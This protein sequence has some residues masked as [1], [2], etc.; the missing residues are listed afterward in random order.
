MAIAFFSE[1]LKKAGFRHGFSTRLASP[2]EVGALVGVPFEA[3][4]RAKQ[5]HSARVIEAEHAGLVADE[6]DALVSRSAFAVAIQT[7]DCVPI[8]IADLR[9]G[10]VAAVHAGWRGVVSGIAPNAIDFLGGDASNL[11]AAIGPCICGTCFEVGADVAEKIA[12]ATDSAVIVRRAGEKA[13]VDLRIAVRTQLVRAGIPDA[14]IEDV[15]GCTYH[16]NDLFFSYRR[17]GANAG[18]LIAVIEP[19]T[20]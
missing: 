11:V 18:R 10:A 12:T 2:E 17:E 3:I 16:Q 19:K 7:A 4:T 13:F 15:A 8:L 5:V 20:L 9:V 14:N 1:A 6:A